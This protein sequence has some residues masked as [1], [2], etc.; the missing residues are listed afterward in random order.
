V[1]IV[2]PARNEAAMVGRTV[3]AALAQRVAGIALDVIVIDDGSTDATADVARQA[4]ARVLATPFETQGN[5]G[6]ARNRGVDAAT[7]EVLVFLDAD[8]VPGEGWLAALVA[9][10]ERGEVVVGGSLGLPSGL[11][12]SARCDYYSSCYHLHPRRPAGYVRHHSPANLSVRGELF[13][14]TGG[15]TYRHPLADGHEE[16][17]WQETVQRLAHRIYFEP[18]AVAEHHNDPGFGNLLRRSYRWGYSGLRGK[19]ETRLSRL[20]WLYGQPRL[21]LAG[22]IPAAVAQAIYIALVWVAARRLEP[23]LMLPGILLSQF[24][25]A[26]G[27]VTGGFRWLH[28]GR[29]PAVEHRPQWR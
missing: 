23:V 1:S 26:A 17:A 16:L 18:R 8:C 15:F 27:F 11:G 25:H 22:A 14:R 3:N 2:I 29:A 10:H 19:A 28:E 5:P 24:A 13:R 4:G 6:A 9:A 7:G 20:G 21:A 12:P